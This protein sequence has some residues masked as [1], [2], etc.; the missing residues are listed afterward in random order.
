MMLLSSLLLFISPVGLTQY[1]QADTEP[2]IAKI[3]K[4]E[5]FSGHFERK[6]FGRTTAKE[7]VTLAFQVGGQIIEFSV[8]EGQ[9]LSQGDVIARLDLEPFELAL[10]QAHIEQLQANR[11]LDRLK[12]LRGSSVSNVAINDAE[13]NAALAEI[14]VKN[15]QRSLNQ[16]TLIAPFSALVASRQRA[17]FS[18]IAA[19]EPIVRLHDM[20]ELRIEINVPEIVFQTIGDNPDYEIRAQFP[21]DSREFIVFPREFNA[22]VSSIGQTF[23]ITLGMPVP[24]AGTILPGSSVTVTATTKNTNPRLLLPASA[25]LTT[26]EGGTEVMI[27]EPINQSEGEVRRVPVS[28]VPSSQGRTEVRSGLT[29]GQEV[30]AVGGAFLRE[31][32]IVRRFE[33]FQN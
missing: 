21:G 18:T 33:S 19:G 23:Q 9:L 11:N 28:I 17:N 24:P 7:T 2:R 6:F 14:K 8:A 16:A 31:G 12:S 10:E 25:F 20:S 32:E 26:S 22:E 30:V 1:A 29:A 27:F 13:T 4:V 5:A 3:I 15:A